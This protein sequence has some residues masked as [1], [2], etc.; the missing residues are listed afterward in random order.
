[1]AEYLVAS[2]GRDS[3]VLISS[4]AAAEGMLVS[5]IAVRDQRPGR[6]VLRGTKVLSSYD[7]LG[8]QHKL[9]YSSPQE[10]QQFLSKS[11]VQAV[12]LDEDPAWVPVHHSLLRQTLHSDPS[13]W[14]LAAAFPRRRGEHYSRDSL[15][16]Y[17]R[18][19]AAPASS[20]PS[21]VR[22]LPLRKR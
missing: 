15:K 4:D 9:L 2:D 8:D 10:V 17:V 18:R 14:R 21:E 12:V 22:Q 13:Q 19:D 20:N 3:T 5:E 11:G 1:V 7:W 16:V 6:R